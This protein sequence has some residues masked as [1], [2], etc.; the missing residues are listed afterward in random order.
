MSVRDD[1]NARREL[2]AKARHIKNVLA[3][4]EKDLTHRCTG[5]YYGVVTYALRIEKGSVRGNLD[6]SSVD[7]HKLN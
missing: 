5:A 7:S 3:L 2:D 1:L 6:V 4:I